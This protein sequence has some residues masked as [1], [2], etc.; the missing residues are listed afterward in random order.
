MNFMLSCFFFF[1]FLCAEGEPS[2]ENS[3]VRAPEEPAGSRFISESHHQSFRPR[4]PPSARLSQPGEKPG[5]DLRESS[6]LNV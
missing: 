1:S 4:E 2:G 3:R 6:E 5:I